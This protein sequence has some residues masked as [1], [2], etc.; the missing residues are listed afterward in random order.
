MMCPSTGT[1][2]KSV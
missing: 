1:G 2:N